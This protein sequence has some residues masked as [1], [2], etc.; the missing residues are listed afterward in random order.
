MS[1]D[2]RRIVILGGGFAG[3]YTAMALERQ[4]SAS[5]RRR[6]EIALVS[7]ENYM[8]FQP[9]L[10]EVISG[11]IEML[12][13]ISPIRRLAKRTSLHT[14]EVQGIDL[15]RRVVTLAPETQPKTRELPFDHLVIALGSRL[16]YDLVPGMREHAM[17]F[18]YLGDALRLRNALVQ[19]LEEADNESDPAERQRLLT[20][21]VGG[22]GFSGV[23]CVAELHDFLVAA[24]P[25]YRTLAARELRAVL[26]Q[27]AGRILPE[28]SEDLAAYAHQILARRGI[29]IRLNTRLK[30]V[31]AR[32]VVIQRKD[33]GEPEVIG[34][35]TVVTTV[36]SA[37]HRLVELLPFEKDR[38]G[39]VV[40]TPETNVVGQPC[41]WALGDC[42][43][44][45][46]PDGITSPPTAQ[47]AV[48]QA[49][50]CAANILA[51]LRG[52]A[53]RRFAF[54]GPGRLASLGHRSAVAEVFGIKLRG[55]LAW[56]VWRAVYLAKFPGLD[57]KARIFTDWC[58]DLFLPRDITEVRIFRPDAVAREHF[59]A[60]EKV[61]D[62]GDVGD[63]AYVV[64][65]GGAEVVRDGGR[66][67]ATLA[68]GDVF[69]EMA[70]ISDKPRSATVRAA[71][72]L[73]VVSIS[74]DAFCTLVKHMPGVRAAMEEALAQHTAGNGDARGDELPV[75]T[76]AGEL[77]H[78]AASGAPAALPGTYPASAPA[79]PTE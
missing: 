58:W 19:A 51:S 70:L 43:A 42:A 68:P 59:H 77:R 4:M 30:A 65:S 7:L 39:R 79:N 60:A 2:K 12:H 50:A 34:S 26:V 3:V 72:P 28:L 13:A 14:R 73:D 54:T 37:P 23:E 61:F 63:K 76:A 35:R 40:V 52:T 55:A 74:R 33:G 66:T 47:H 15:E 48:R 57:R 45:P 67:V 49:T 11:T 31:T 46:Q 18:K 38:E 9:L 53:P 21:V 24:L 62:Q 78:E 41:I 6:Y 17:S 16:D 27:S 69:G 29:D 8:V 25:A 10:P 56:L 64:V 32:G 44:V 5:E 71:S 20:F 75:A 1:D 36:P 22:G